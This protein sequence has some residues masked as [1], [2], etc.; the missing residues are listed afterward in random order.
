MYRGEAVGVDPVLRRTNKAVNHGQTGI[1]TLQQMW[2]RACSRSAVRTALDLKGA[3]KVM[4]S[5]CQT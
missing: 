3:R 4:T 1:G 2:E 5:T